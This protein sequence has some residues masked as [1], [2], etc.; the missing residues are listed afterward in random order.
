MRRWAEPLTILIVFAVVMT[1]L[2]WVLSA[3]VP[4]AIDRLISSVGILAAWGI[5]IVVWLA[6]GIYA[7]YAHR[8]KAGSA[9]GKYGRVRSD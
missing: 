4:S 3:T 2:G 1:A 8:P 6:A 9:A 7:W 5:F